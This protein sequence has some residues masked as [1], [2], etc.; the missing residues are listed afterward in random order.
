MK[1]K[2]MNQKKKGLYIFCDNN[3]VRIRSIIFFFL[4]LT[5][6]V[7]VPLNIYTTLVGRIKM[8]T[9]AQII[10]LYSRFLSLKPPKLFF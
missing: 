2:F 8:C 5:C 10:G 1:K 9:G 3:L 4:F 7:F 6:V